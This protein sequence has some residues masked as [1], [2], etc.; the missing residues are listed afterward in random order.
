MYIQDKFENIISSKLKSIY[1][2]YNIL[3]IIGVAILGM[4]Q[5]IYIYLCFRLLK[6]KS[7]KWILDPK[8]PKIPPIG[9]EDQNDIEVQNEVQNDSEVHEGGQKDPEVQKEVGRDWRPEQIA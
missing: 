7:W 8:V 3:Y 6:I 9:P 2:K 5:I 4:L 1:I